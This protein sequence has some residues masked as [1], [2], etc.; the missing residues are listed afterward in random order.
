MLHSRQRRDDDKRSEAL[1]R[2]IRPD[3]LEQHQNQWGL[4]DRCEDWVK[5][6]GPE[7]LDIFDEKVKNMTVLTHAKLFYT[8][9]TLDIK[10]YR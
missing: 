7:E 9:C 5:E 1:G 4:M 2:G 6:D 8:R 10:G 3:W